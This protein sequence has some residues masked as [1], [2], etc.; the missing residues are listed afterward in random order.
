MK[1]VELKGLLKN[2][3]F[4]GPWDYIQFITIGIFIDEYFKRNGYTIES[5]DIL[6]RMICGLSIWLELIIWIFK[7]N[8]N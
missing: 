2:P 5:F 4:K 3:I 8:A 7:R 1:G 6:L